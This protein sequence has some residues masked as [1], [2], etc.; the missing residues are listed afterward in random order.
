MKIRRTLD[1]RVLHELYAQCF[2][3]EALPEWERCAWWQ[4]ED[5]PVA[6]AGV[7]TVKGDET[8]AYLERAGVH[9]VA[10]G[11]G[12]QRRLIRVRCAWAKRNGCD[13]VI[14]YTTPDNYWS[15]NNLIECG[16]RLYQPEW[17]WAGTEVLYWQKRITQLKNNSVD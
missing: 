15:S 3:A 14:T 5:P 4:V 12:L 7:R 9:K 10:R 8:T 1:H 13:T 2:P 6:F 17:P 16:F 11:R